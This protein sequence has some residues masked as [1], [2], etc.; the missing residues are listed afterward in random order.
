MK[1]FNR[2]LTLLLS[3]ALIGFGVVLAVEVVGALF[4]S[5]PLLIDWRGAYR[6]GR[7]DRWDSAIVRVL[8]SAIALV[9]LL[10]LLAQLKPRRISRLTVSSDDP[11]TDAALTRAGVRSALRRAAEDVD[12]ISAAKVKISRRSAK[13]VA[14]TRASQPSLGQTLN[15]DVQVAV[16]ERLTA[17]QLHHPP[18]V[19]TS[20]KTRKAQS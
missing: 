13:V 19:R 18:R 7:S 10:L 2:L 14:S 6:A 8:A 17:L 16:A 9:G 20:V 4:G 5:H 11:H 12:G 1:A 3:V 15:A